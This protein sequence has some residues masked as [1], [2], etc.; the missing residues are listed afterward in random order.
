MQSNMHDMRRFVQVCLTPLKLAVT[1]LTSS[2]LN[3]ENP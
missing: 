1:C 3:L 2:S